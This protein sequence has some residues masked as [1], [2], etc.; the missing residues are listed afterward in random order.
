VR[1]ARRPALEVAG[2]LPSG[3]AL[4]IGVLEMDMDVK[5]HQGIDIDRGRHGHVVL[6]GVDDDGD[7]RGTIAFAGGMGA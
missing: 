1:V 3:V 2:G 4:V 5:G 6:A 7:V